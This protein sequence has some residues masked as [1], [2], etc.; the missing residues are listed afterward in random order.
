MSISFLTRLICIQVVV[1]VLLPL[2]SFAEDAG[3]MSQIDQIGS[4]NE[5]TIQQKFV[6]SGLSGD[7][8]NSAIAS[9]TGTGNTIGITQEG[10]SLTANVTQKGDE[11]EASVE[12]NGTGHTASVEQF[13][14]GHNATIQQNGPTP[15]EITIMQDN[16]YGGPGQSITVTQP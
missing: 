5:A 1:A 4:A 11:L 15:R 3:N 14:T 13:G 10:A 2:P 16:M 8:L 12:Q 7:T 9:Q 6:A